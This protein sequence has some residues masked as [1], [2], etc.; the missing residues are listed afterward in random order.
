MTHMINLAGNYY[1][2]LLNE[3]EQIKPLINVNDMPE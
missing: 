1:P 2:V 3:L